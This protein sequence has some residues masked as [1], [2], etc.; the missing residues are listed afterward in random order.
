M[1]EK[2]TSPEKDPIENLFWVFAIYYQI[3]YSSA[4]L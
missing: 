1:S 4:V 3:L 2:T